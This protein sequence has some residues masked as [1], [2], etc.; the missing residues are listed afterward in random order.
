[1][2]FDLLVHRKSQYFNSIR[3]QSTFSLS[4]YQFGID[5]DFR[6]IKGSKVVLG[7]DFLGHIGRFLRLHDVGMWFCGQEC[8]KT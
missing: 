5:S 7:N 8:L 3:L 4:L 2:D 1:M 6:Q